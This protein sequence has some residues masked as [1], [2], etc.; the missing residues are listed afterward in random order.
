MMHDESGWRLPSLPLVV[1]QFAGATNTENLPNDMLINWRGKPF[2]YTYVT[3]S[4]VFIDLASKDKKRPQD[5]FSNKIV[6][7]GS[8][9]PGLF[10]IKPTAMD[11]QFPGVDGN[12]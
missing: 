12:R 4:D 10:D 6:I 1:A 7:I 2:S 8:T 5:E 9:A 3:F 11:K